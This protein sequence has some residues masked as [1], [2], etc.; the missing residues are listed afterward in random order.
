VPP[1]RHS[2]HRR[3]P[4]S[5]AGFTIVELLVALVVTGMVLSVAYGALH[6]AGQATARVRRERV[7]ALEGPSA[8][9]ALDGW[10]RAATL[11]GGSE[12]FVGLADGRGGG[13]DRT[14][15][16]SFAVLDAGSLRPGPHR[17]RLWIGS[18][19]AAGRRGLLAELRPIRG[20]GETPAET[21]RVAP[22][23]TGLAL[24]YLVRATNR[25]WWTDAWQSYEQ[26]PAA[27]ELRVL[28][29]PATGS[30]GLPPILALPVRVPL[31]WTRR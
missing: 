9:A 8:R 29:G 17:V 2:R 24:R 18:D 26:L 11:A 21:L 10:L 31:G 4:A 3:R 22:A 12:A 20:V 1:R 27:V 5:L 14:D 6:V 7:A 30:S 15:E 25:E 13:G 16:V 28:A 23:A 19:S